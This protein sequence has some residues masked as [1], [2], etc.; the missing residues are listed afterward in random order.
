MPPFTVLLYSCGKSLPALPSCR[1]A[2]FCGQA[3]KACRYIL[4]CKRPQSLT[5]ALIM[6]NLTLAKEFY[7][8]V[9]VGVI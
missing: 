1:C 7:Y 3:C 8:V 6:D 9:D 4:L 5:E 2:F